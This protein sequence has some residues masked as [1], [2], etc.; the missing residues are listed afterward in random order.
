MDRNS[1]FLLD[2]INT[3]LG[4]AA[5]ALDASMFGPEVAWPR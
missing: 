5:E 3:V 1:D 2:A 4:A